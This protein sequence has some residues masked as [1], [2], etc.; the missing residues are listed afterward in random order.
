MQE[1]SI[2]PGEDLPEEIPIEGSGG[3]TFM[4][5][6]LYEWKMKKC[7]K[8]NRLG[9]EE[10]ECRTEMNNKK[11]GQKKNHIEVPN[12]TVENSDAMV[13]TT[14]T[15]VVDVATTSTVEVNVSPV[16][17]PAVTTHSPRR[18]I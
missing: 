14:L 12:M 17:Q 5:K 9:H 10:A 15:H 2:K 13:N 8:C 7:S 1:C 11:N 18:E 4:Q 3:I 16:K 6:V